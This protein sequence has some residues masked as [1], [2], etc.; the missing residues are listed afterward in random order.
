MP[1]I[2]DPAVDAALDLTDVRLL[3]RSRNSHEAQS[4]DQPSVDTDPSY[5]LSTAFG[6]AMVV[7]G[8]YRLAVGVQAHAKSLTVP[9]WSGAERPAGGRGHGRETYSFPP[10]DN[11][12]LSPP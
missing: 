12:F 8:G 3:T 1:A 9:R 6:A 10:V 5:S 4:D 11:V 2:S 7:A